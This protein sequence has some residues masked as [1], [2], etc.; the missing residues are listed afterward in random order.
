M[1]KSFPL[2]MA[3]VLILLGLLFGTD[4]PQQ[5]GAGQ[6][7]DAEVRLILVDVVVTE[8][9]RFIA[10]LQKEDFEL[11]EDNRLIP[12]NSFE[13]VSFMSTESK[14]ERTER[15]TDTEASSQKKLAV[16]FDGINS[17]DL[18][19]RNNI[20]GIT[21]EL[22][23]LAQIGHEVLVC[24]LSESEGIEILQPFTSDDSLISKAVQKASGTMWMPGQ[25]LHS[26]RIDEWVNNW[27]EDPLQQT[28]SKYAGRLGFEEP[29]SSGN[30]PEML[31]RLQLSQF[32]TEE[33]IR[34][35]KT[36][37]A[38]L[39]TVNMLRTYPGRKSLLLISGG[40]PD[41]TPEYISSSY[42]GGGQINLGTESFEANA[43][44][45]SR[46]RSHFMEADQIRR[47]R[48]FDPFELMAKKEF[49]V[50][51]EVIRELINYANTQNIS[52]YSLDAGIFSRYVYPGGGTA[53][54]LDER[55]SPI[56]SLLSKERIKRV[57]NLRWLS[58]DT[59]AESLRGADKFEEFQHVLQTD[60]NNHYQLS[61][62]PP[63]KK[64]DDKY[65]KLRVRVD[66][67]GVNVRHRTGYTDYSPEEEHRI[68]LITAFYN[69]SLFDD[70]PFEGAF[71][72]F[73]NEEGEYEP[74]IN[75]ALPTEELFIE[76]FT[77]HG[78][79]RYYLH[80]WVNDS[81][82][83]IK[84][85]GGTITL[86]FNVNP[87]F[88]EYMQTLSHLSYHFK[89]TVVPFP[90]PVYQAVFALVD[91]MADEIGT[92]SSEFT[93]P[94]LKGQEDTFINFVVG[95]IVSAKKREKPEFALSKDSG[96]LGY[97]R[98]QFFPK[99]TRLTI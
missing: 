95:G 55:D 16:I 37:G 93:I 82:A 65:H 27:K 97:D 63:R 41:M 56:K 13:L 34:F 98:I 62:Y 48:I 66:R 67:R 99:V 74:W 96:G 40:I 89:G 17:L 22:I 7:H 51:E 30:D 33:K 61:F 83:G 53:E 26:T 52:I 36:I 43:E 59:G 25:T 6:E 1:K 38:M 81:V 14:A 47:I 46:M 64:P 42:L 85:Y 12:I 32:F 79:K 35:E 29:I 88:L 24:Q 2:I 73:L 20:D 44:T 71:Y 39:A 23:N 84:G 69:P 94:D 15:Q 72:P 28:F 10:G 8:D 77:G 75:V 86:P 90:N 31:Y 91:P 87:Q 58:E 4:R 3:G 76:R 60:L 18:E 70:L 21:E 54:S 45:A 80:V 49:S 92:W 19:I 11:Y 5:T 78:P 50:G 68:R 9:G 57:Q